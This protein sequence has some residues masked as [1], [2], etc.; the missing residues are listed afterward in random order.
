MSKIFAY[1]NALESLLCLLLS[2]GNGS[3]QWPGTRHKKP[4]EK[5]PACSHFSL[6]AKRSKSV[7]NKNAPNNIEKGWEKKQEKSS[8]KEISQARGGRSARH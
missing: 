6:A 2:T 1:A 3:K 4:K 5:R 8:G 7:S